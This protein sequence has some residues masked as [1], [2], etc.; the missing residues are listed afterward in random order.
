MAICSK[1]MPPTCPDVEGPQARS[2]SAASGRDFQSEE[3]DEKE[4]ERDE[5]FGEDD[6]EGEKEFDEEQDDE[7]VKVLDRYY[8]Y[9]QSL[10]PTSSTRGQE[11]NY[12]PIRFLRRSREE[13][14]SP[15]S[16]P[17]REAQRSVDPH[18]ITTGGN[19][20]ALTEPVI[21]FVFKKD[22]SAAFLLMASNKSS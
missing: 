18:I 15:T 19:S 7:E 1:L 4:E 2:D 11:H 20:D 8:G 9:R 16:G 13:A 5:D 3:D 17:W 10:L 14:Y 21:Q 6:E 12:E 22:L